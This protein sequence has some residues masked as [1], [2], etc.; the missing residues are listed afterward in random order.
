VIVRPDRFLPA[1]FL[2][3]AT[4]LSPLPGGRAQDA[5]KADPLLWPEPQ[6][7][8]FQDGPGLLLGPQRRTALL[9][10][11][12][13]GRA[14]LIADFYAAGAPAAVPAGEL[15]QAI[16]RRQRL[17]TQEFFSPT[18]VRWKL[19][20]LNG[21][22]A[23]RKV[24]DCGIAFKPV[25]IWTY[26]GAVTGEPQVRYAVVFRSAPDEPYRMWDSTDSKRILYSPEMEYWLQQWE[27]NRGF[28]FGRRFDRQ[29]CKEAELVDKA[30]GVNGLTGKHG[31]GDSKGRRL[32]GMRPG[33]ADGEGFLDPPSDLGRWVHDAASGEGKPATAAN[34]PNAVN[35]AK[36]Q[37][38][39]A[40]P[41]FE[42]EFPERAGQRMMARG[43]V[44]VI[45]ARLE[46]EPRSESEAPAGG[47]KAGAGGAEKKPATASPSLAEAPRAPAGASRAPAGTTPAPPAAASPA[48]PAS[49]TPP[50]VSPGAQNLPPAPDSATLPSAPSTPA[51]AVRTGPPVAG[52]TVEGVIEADG[53]IFESFR[54]RY[55]VP[56]VG[57]NVP[58]ALAIDR[59]LR[60]GRTFLMRLRIKDEATGAE[61]IATRGFIVPEQPRPPA[62]PVLAAA[63]PTAAVEGGSDAA[64]VRMVVHGR[65]TVTLVP[66]EDDVILGLWRTQALVTGERIVKVTFS[67]D[68][69]AEITRTARPYTVEIRLARFP[70][71]QVVRADGYDAAG[72]LVASDEVVLNEPRGGLKVSVLEPLRG[73]KVTA[74]KV[75]ARAEVTVPQ[76]RR[77]Q[78]VEFRVN[79]VLQA[80]LTK[81]PWE[82][83]VAVPA[84]VET[85]YLTVAA[86]LDDGSR[87]ED[88]RFL[89][90][91][92]FVEQV[93]VNLVELYTT[94]VDGNGQPV[95]GLTANDF[96]VLQ[97]GKPQKLSRF[98]LVENL[99]LTLGILID[100]SGSMATSLPEAKRAAGGFLE[101][102]VRPGDRCFTV[103]F[104]DHPVLHMPLTDDA[105]AAAQSLDNLQAIGATSI[106]DAI[107]HSL[108]FFRGTRGQRAIVLLSDGDDNSSELTFD[109]ALEYSKR[110]GVSIYVIGLDI[111]KLSVGIRGK[112]N[113][114]TEL[115]GGKVFYVSRAAE[116]AGTYAEIEHELR[117]RYLLAFESDVAAGE[118]GYRA[119]EVKVLKPGLK[120]RA[121][122]GY[123]P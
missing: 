75:K 45:A 108:Y 57:Q 96:E 102:L 67:V 46:K 117:S 94:V 101:R 78:A 105:R 86:Q 90:S 34:A 40:V 113:K 36:A 112:L 3:L 115:T 20:F 79:D 41:G 15:R 69:K 70:V 42:V 87:A 28:S 51:A 68:G 97:G 80:T 2:L 84:G 38:P 122:R 27:E 6:R 91:P 7:A 55:R 30:T 44:Q 118:G 66:P 85:V 99:P 121:A 5:P 74:E 29:V 95:R 22:P 59:A 120:A 93:E 39:L 26:R 60:P 54:L 16:E 104:S 56:W 8:F 18:D 49:S 89:R 62:V 63:T 82:S 116:L 110:S 14:R 43:I 114:L 47:E 111:S 81:P 64:V 21:K 123:Y 35:A 50:P 103:T 76:E 31:S 9:A 23:E 12:D 25:E 19:L 11:D 98:E 106:H 65:D 107:V 71:E 58:V 10:A 100:T 52:L 77:V 88:V 17:A 73:A 109:E 53:R 92:Q 37:A 72:Q 48:P 83:E 13:A 32:H 33:G 24:V 1:V 119:V 4:A 61:S